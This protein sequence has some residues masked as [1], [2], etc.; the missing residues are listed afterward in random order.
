MMLTWVVGPGNDCPLCGAEGQQ[1][2]DEGCPIA[3]IDVYTPE[4]ALRALS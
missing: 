1:R 4:E 2:C 3:S